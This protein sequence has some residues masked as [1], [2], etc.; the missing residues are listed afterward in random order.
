MD[1]SDDQQRSRVPMVQSAITMR[2]FAIGD[3]NSY[4][5]ESDQY[6]IVVP[7][8]DVATQTEVHSKATPAHL[9]RSDGT[10]G[11]AND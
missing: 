9:S 1:F 8:V 11:I 6:L 5:I 10:A 4:A 3:E 2:N 7:E